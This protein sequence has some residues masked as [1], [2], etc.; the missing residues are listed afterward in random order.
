MEHPFELVARA[1]VL[2]VSTDLDDL[3]VLLGLFSDPRFHP[4]QIAAGQ[5]IGIATLFA[6]SAVGSLISLI[7]PATYLGFLGLVPITMGLTKVWELRTSRI[8]NTA[9]SADYPTRQERANIAAVFVV[10]VANGG[11]NLSVYVPLFAMRSGPDIAMIGIVFAI[12]TLVWLAFAFW[13]TQHGTAGG[14]IRRYARLLMPFVLIALGVLIL[15]E[16]GTVKLLF[17]DR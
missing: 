5:L 13:L 6:I 14:P 17:S 2:F 8:A 16:A 15:K 11:D 1:V 4:R 10:T 12:M 9:G 7:L 3:F